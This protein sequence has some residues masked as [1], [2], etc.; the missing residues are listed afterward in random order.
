MFVLLGGKILFI[1]NWC[2]AYLKTTSLII[3]LSKTSS[4]ALEDCETYV[5]LSLY[6]SIDNLVKAS[7]VIL[8]DIGFKPI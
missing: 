7:L 8:A 6:L 2:L 5:L 3:A 4:K 1:S